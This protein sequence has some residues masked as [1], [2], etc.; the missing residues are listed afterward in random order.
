MRWI[1]AVLSY[2][3]YSEGRSESYDNSAAVFLTISLPQLRHYYVLKE[4]C[5]LIYDATAVVNPGI[6]FE[7]CSGDSDP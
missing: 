4:L 3:I 6:I 1:T 2:K 5:T 7:R